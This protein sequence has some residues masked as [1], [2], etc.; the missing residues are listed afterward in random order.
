[1]IHRP[2]PLGWCA[3]ILGSALVIP[4]ADVQCQEVRV[5]LIVAEAPDA[6]SSHGITAFRNAVLDAGPDVSIVGALT[7]ATD[8]IE[9]RDYRWNPED[10]RG[11]CESWLFS[12]RP[13]NDPTGAHAAS[14]KPAD[15]GVNVCGH[16]AEECARKSAWMLRERLEP[17]LKHIP[18]IVPR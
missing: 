8:L 2:I 9:L 13:L 4:P 15:L 18:R 12:Y 7:G 3:A 5:R 16:T 17:L 1:M 10:E 11:V 6:V 14:S